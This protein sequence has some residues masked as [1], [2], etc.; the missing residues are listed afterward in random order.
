MPLA[1]ISASRSPECLRVAGAR[2]VGEEAREVD[3]PAQGGPQTLFLK[4]G[5]TLS[6]VEPFW[7]LNRVGMTSDLGFMSPFRPRVE[8]G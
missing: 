5:L 3:R 4:R 1:C 6:E 7:V 2:W 8:N